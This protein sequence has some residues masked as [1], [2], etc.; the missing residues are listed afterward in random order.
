MA[1]VSYGIIVISIFLAVPQSLGQNMVTECISCPRTPLGRQMNFVV[2]CDMVILDNGDTVVFTCDPVENC[3]KTP[4]NDDNGCSFLVSVQSFNESQITYT[5]A[6]AALSS[7]DVCIGSHTF[8]VSNI[9]EIEDAKSF[10]CEC[11]SDNCNKL[12]N[13][14]FSVTGTA[15]PSTAHT[16]SSGFSVTGISPLSTTPHTSAISHALKSSLSITTFT[17]ENPHSSK[18]CRYCSL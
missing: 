1:H 15:S 9:Q 8:Y 10:F 4:V 2:D 3:T 16:S 13:I 14:T 17:T 6:E 11:F 7:A 12:N 5:A 18:T